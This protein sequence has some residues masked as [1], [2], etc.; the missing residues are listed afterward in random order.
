MPVTAYDLIVIGAGPG[1]YVAAIRAA[2]LGL[3]IAIIESRST[4]GGTC[5]NIGC[6]PSKAL[7][8]S[9]EH[10]YS[11]RNHF[12]EHGITVKD[13]SIDLKT[14]MMRKERV[15]G[16]LTGGVSYLMKKNK[17][18]V[19]NGTGTITSPGEVQV[20][21]NSGEKTALKTGSIIIA[22]GSVP[23]ELPFLPFDGKRIVDSE[24]ALSFDS[25]PKKLSIVGA[26]AIGL[27]MASVWSRLGSEVSVIEIMAGILPGWDAELA[28]GL[29]KELEKQ[30]IKFLLGHKV[31]G[32]KNTKSGVSLI[33]ET[34]DGKET[35]L[36][37]DRVL[38]SV[39]RRPSYNRGEMDHLGIALDERNRIAV[40]RNF[41]TSVPGIYA[42]GDIIA[43]PML[44]H[45]AEEDGALAAEV[46]AGKA[47]PDV[48]YEIVPGVVYTNPEAASAGRTEEVLK[49][50][51][52]PYGKGK[53]PFKA[54]G[55]AIAGGSD[56]GFVKVLSH[57][58][59]DRILGVHILGS[60]A[61]VLIA[62]A[63]AVM[64]FGGSSEDIG[65][66]IHAH[67][68]LS[69]SLKEA[70]LDVMGLGIHI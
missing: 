44:A 65:R 62:E 66:T 52:I 27:E 32:S 47:I 6:I 3:K 4:L 36:T 35:G 68:T 33:V 70:A 40:D 14:L 9:T 2:Q 29:Q 38:V 37:G 26:G 41:Q 25:V 46:I 42:I 48:D 51:K 22:T 53:F 5:L 15:V 64:E 59:T 30:G 8:S 16:K 13:I 69:E 1:G 18:D 7:L 19:F 67:P 60:E 45:K 28:K 57:K 31:S 23:V 34:P 63:V 12:S 61:S 39:G 24:A 17:I 55:R 54:N 11:A 56:S 20:E 43:G 21:K 50:Q 58:E 49:E 10:Y